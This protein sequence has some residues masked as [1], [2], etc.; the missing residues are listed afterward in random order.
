MKS[1]GVLGVPSLDRFLSMEPNEMAFSTAVQEGEL[2][3]ELLF[4]DDP[5]EAGRVAAHPAILWKI[6]TDKRIERL[7]GKSNN[8]WPSVKSVDKD[9]IEAAVAA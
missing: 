4:P 2:K 5:A 3:P 7:D 8:L 1:S 6:L 9:I